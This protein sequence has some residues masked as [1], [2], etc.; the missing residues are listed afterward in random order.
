MEDINEKLKEIKNEDHIWVIYIFIIF[1]SW[2]ANSLE[3]KYFVFKDE[4]SKIK[5]RKTMILIFSILV[6]I[7]F[8]FFKDS[9]NGLKSIK[10]CD[11]EKKKKL[12]Y[13]SF[14]GAFLILLSGFIFLYIAYKDEDIDVE[15]AFN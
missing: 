2:Y 11:S 5:Y 13:L 14:V 9:L 3:R 10:T 6:I 7:Y 1:L 12:I 8:Y 4:K 15:I